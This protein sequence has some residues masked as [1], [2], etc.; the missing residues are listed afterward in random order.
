MKI[1]RGSIVKI[2]GQDIIMT[3]ED[4]IGNNVHLLYFDAYN[5]LIRCSVNIALVVNQIKVSDE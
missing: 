3:V 4:V 5:M 1:E 2:I